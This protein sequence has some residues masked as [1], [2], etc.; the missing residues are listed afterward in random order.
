MGAECICFISIKMFQSY[1]QHYQSQCQ[2]CQQPP[3][4]QPCQQNQYGPVFCTTTTTC[5]APQQPYMSSIREILDAT[6]E[7]PL[8]IKGSS[9]VPT[10]RK[11]EYVEPANLSAYA[12]PR[13]SGNRPLSPAPPLCPILQPGRDGLLWPRSDS[14]GVPVR[15]NDDIVPGFGAGMSY[16]SPMPMSVGSDFCSPC[17]PCNTSMPWSSPSG[18]STPCSTGCSTNYAQTSYGQ[19]DYGFMPVRGGY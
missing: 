5:V 10:Y 15:S 2:P 19:P 7:I 17:D 18:C 12:S 3:T 4:C 11:V 8:P 9:I 6:P 16:A 13:K 1:D 14:M